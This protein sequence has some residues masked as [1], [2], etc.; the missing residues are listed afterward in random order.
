[1]NVSQSWEVAARQDPGGAEGRTYSGIPLEARREQRRRRLLDAGLEE[2]GTRGYDQVTVKDVCRR[3]GLTERYFYEQFSDRHGL[4]V[5][6]YDDVV[7]FV[8]SVTL[9]AAE[10]APEELVSRAR[11]GLAAFVGAL[12]DDPRRARV[13]LI[14]SVGRGVELERR[15]SEVMRAFADYV[16]QSAEL[17]HPRPD[18]SPLRRAALASALVGATNHLVVEWV[19]GDLDMSREELVDTLVTLH[20]AVADAPALDAGASGRGHAPE[21]S[22]RTRRGRR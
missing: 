11:A 21:R 18:I 1:M 15:R 6:V 5:A 20:L 14:E 19:L 22:E 13:Q 7:G 12:A 10:S 9:A 16:Q 2:I 8:L 4:L 17:L 3:A